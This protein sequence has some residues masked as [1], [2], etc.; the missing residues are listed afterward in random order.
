MRMPRVSANVLVALVV[1]STLGCADSVGPDK[2]VVPHAVE[3]IAG[4]GQ[5][6]IRGTSFEL[7]LTVRVLG[8]EGQRLAGETV[9]WTLVSG[10]A[11][12]GSQQSV[13]NGGG[14]A[15]VMVRN[16]ATVGLLIVTA[17]V[18]D[19]APA[20][21]SLTGVN[22]CLFDFAPRIAP[23]SSRW[24]TL[25]PLDCAPDSR[26]SYDLF[27]FTLYSQTAVKMSVRS[28]TFDPAV[29]LD[30][31]TNWYLTV[32]DTVDA[33]RDAKFKAI[34][35]AGTY[36]M[37]ATSQAPDARGEYEIGLSWAPENIESCEFVIT[38]VGVTTTQKL[39]PTDCA[40]STHGN[41][42]LIGFLLLPGEGLRAT[43]SSTAFAPYLQL[44]RGSVVLA[45]QSAGTTGSATVEYVA[46]R[47]DLYWVH[48]SSELAGRTGDYTLS[49]AFTDNTAAR[50]RAAPR[51]WR[52]PGDA[53]ELRR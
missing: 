48:A 35:P 33:T 20:R 3:I 9:R 6:A 41:E 10:E 23:G 40:G 39:A 53:R 42:D 8:S 29:M 45:E 17:T 18:R 22:P 1:G 32:F 12:L 38:L 24:G 28:A 36:G 47:F 44:T 25:A 43:E 31:K 21:F 7:P 34:L 11:T 2:R 30:A 19:V 15:E 16:A 50:R 14:V 46:D 49:T 4:D 52:F 5:S 13:T 27:Q 37:A 51:A 26:W